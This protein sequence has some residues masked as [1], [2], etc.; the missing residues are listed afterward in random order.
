MVQNLIAFVTDDEP[1]RHSR[2]ALIFECFLISRLF[3]Y[4]YRDNLRVGFL[5]KRLIILSNLGLTDVLINELNTQSPTPNCIS[6]QKW[7]K[8][9]YIYPSERV[10]NVYYPATRWGDHLLIKASGALMW[11]KGDRDQSSSSAF[12]T[13]AT[14]TPRKAANL[15]I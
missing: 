12:I 6:L 1:W 10:I 13:L 7:K 14:P 8:T 15:H 9:H 2:C 11:R 4:V 5:L 3:F